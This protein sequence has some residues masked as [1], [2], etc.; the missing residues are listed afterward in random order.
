MLLTS[1][2]GTEISVIDLEMQPS[3][4]PF[5]TFKWMLNGIPAVNASDRVVYGYPSVT[6]YNVSRSDAGT[7][8]LFAENFANE[9]QIVGNDTG[10]FTIDVLCKFYL[11]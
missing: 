6:F 4:F 7:Y 5:P 9:T 10:S 8:T 3:A 2:E 11:T 1:L